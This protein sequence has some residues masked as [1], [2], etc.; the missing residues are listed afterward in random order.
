[1]AADYFLIKIQLQSAEAPKI[2]NDITT[3][4]LQLG[5]SVS[6]LTVKKWAISVIDQEDA[7]D[8]AETFA[9]AKQLAEASMPGEVTN[10]YVDSVTI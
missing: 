1:M 7:T 5:D 6:D 3:G 9:L 8:L 2:V 4:N 10:I